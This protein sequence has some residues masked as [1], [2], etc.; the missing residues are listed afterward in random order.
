MLQNGATVSDVA[1]LIDR[2][3]D[4]TLLPRHLVVE[5]LGAQPQSDQQYELMGFDGSRSF[6]PM[7]V[8]DMIFSKRVFRGP[9]LLIEEEQGVLGRDILNH[10]KLHL[11]GPNEQWE[12]Q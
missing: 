10:I 8:L 9:Y 12:V 6:A 11:N 4:I 2:G 5:Q 7:V 3:A 1:L